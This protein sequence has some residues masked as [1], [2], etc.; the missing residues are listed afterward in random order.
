MAG[1][2]EF[3]VQKLVAL[4]ADQ[5]GAT[6]IEYGLI[7]ALISTA[8]ILGMQAI[9]TNINAIFQFLADTFTNAMA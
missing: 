2:A 3:V 8:V 7:V 6:V 9:G 5:Q 1:R 4:Y